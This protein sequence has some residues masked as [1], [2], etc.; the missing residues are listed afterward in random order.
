MDFKDIA[1]GARDMTDTELKRALY[2]CVRNNSKLK[3]LDSKNREVLMDIIKKFQKYLKR[4][5][6]ISSTMIRREMYD[7]S[8]NQHK[9]GL[10]DADM[11][12]L[13]EILEEF[14]S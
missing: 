8:R 3:N 13:K 14:R 5:I 4:N 1:E 7:L 9:L 12:D 11:D 10:D 6:G 2:S